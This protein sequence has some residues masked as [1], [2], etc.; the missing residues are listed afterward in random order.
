MIK[1]LDKS[2]LAEYAELIRRSFATVA[3]DLGLTRENSP[4][5]TSFIT[6]EMLASKYRK[7]YFPFGYFSGERLIGFVS[8]TDEGGGD[9]ELNNLAVLPECRHN[10]YGRELVDFC[11]AKTRELGGRRI[12]IGIIEENLRAKNWYASQGFRHTGAK[13]FDHM[14]FTAGFMEWEAL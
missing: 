12:K 9:Y 10:G 13:K 1:P 6:D 7:G 8:L 14:A 3:S 5:H 11:K 4:T 2:F